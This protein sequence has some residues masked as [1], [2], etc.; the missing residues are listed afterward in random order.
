M[1]FQEEIE[2]YLRSRFTVIW[3]ASYEEE[4][5]ITA[6]K[7][8]CEQNNRRLITWDVADW[9][10]VIVDNGGGNPPDARDPRTALEAIAKAEPGRDAVFLLKDFHNCL[11][12][13]PIITR[14]LRNLAQALKSTR[15]T[16]VITSPTTK[17]PDD[18]KDDIFLMEFPPPDVEEM[19][20]ILERFINNPRIR[21]QLTELGREKVLQAALGLSSNQAQ[22]VFG[23]CIV[24]ELRNPDGR[25]IKPAG[26]LDENG[27]DLITQEKKAIIRESGA[28]EFYAPQETIADV[29]GL[30]VLKGW[31]RQREKAFTKEARDYGLPSPKGIALIGIP[32][33]GKSLTAKMAAGLWHLPLV[34]LDVGALFGSLVGQSEENTRRALA[35]VE[36]I[37]P[38]LMWIDE[39]EK[40]FAQG[41]GDGGTSQRVFNNILFWM[42]EKKKPVFVIGTANDITRLPPEFLRR[43]RFD[44]IFFL[45]LPTA[46]ERREIFQVHIQKRKRPVANY[47]LDALAAASE[48]Y[49]GA[50][51]EQAV[52]DAMYLAFN[53][54][55]TPGRDFTTKDILAALKRLVPLARSQRESI[56][57]LRNWLREGRAQSASYQEVRYWEENIV[58]LQIGPPPSA[59]N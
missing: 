5:I 27:I 22:R 41:G 15:K 50:E 57:F 52:I 30:E 43:G 58:N 46:A 2:I 11:E 33:T 20:G 28:L 13:Q 4:R 42:Q 51:I 35:L 49:V 1:R 21:V 40:A 54:E 12:K 32:G 6:L 59:T 16:I 56:K 47:D 23:K 7:A 31:L 53:D 19:R 34:R 26:T 48:G 3:V 9:F 45:D 39:M 25:L 38:C 24:A 17:I 55:R 29:G 8:V 14:Q 10:K 37:A 44:E 18:L 36:T